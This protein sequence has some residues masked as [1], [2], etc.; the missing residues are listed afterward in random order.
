MSAQDVRRYPIPVS[1]NLLMFAAALSGCLGL[2]W[3][4]SH[5][6][7][8]WAFLAAAGFAVLN[9]TLFTLMHEAIHGVLLPHPRANALLGLACGALVPVPLA[10]YAYGHMQ[11][12]VRNRT[13]DELFDYYLPGDSRVRKNAWL[14]LGNLLGG[15]WALMALATVLYL[16]CPWFCRSPRRRREAVGL[17]IGA[18]V[19]DIA[20]LPLG[21]TW[22]QCLFVALTQAAMIYFLELSLSGWLLCYGAF[23]LHWSA[24]QYTHHAWSARD[25]ETGAWNLRVFAPV[26]WLSLN[27]HY[28]LAHHTHPDIPWIYLGQFVGEQETRPSFWKNYLTLWGGVRPAPPMLKKACSPNAS[29]PPLATSNT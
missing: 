9:N 25:V 12:H 23:A 11:H 5:L 4:A 2:L 17:G 13:D 22:L 10:A 6:S 29:A 15:F 1:L 3:A 28:H 27:Y 14:Y 8:G 24:L 19:G 18:G 26:R 16:L 7:I 20:Q 21:K